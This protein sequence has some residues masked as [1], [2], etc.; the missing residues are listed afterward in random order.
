[1]L[2]TVLSAIAGHR[3]V[4]GHRHDIVG[5]HPVML[6]LAVLVA[7]LHHAAMKLHRI[8]HFRAREFPRI[9]VTQ[10]V[11]RVLHLPA[12]FDLLV[13]HAV[14]V[15]DA[16]AVAGQSDGCHGIEEAGSQSAKAA[17]AE[18]GIEFQFRNLVQVNARF[19]AGLAEFLC[20]AD[21]EHAVHQAAPDEEFHGEVIH[22]LCSHRCSNGAW[23]PSSVRPCVR[24]QRGRAK[25]TSRGQW[26]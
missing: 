21:V 17:V 4:I 7:V 23:F 16:H 8:K 24:E 19:D 13:E 12:V 6:H 3:R 22:S 11:V 25:R 9:A 2:L 10:P 20:K 5:I 14:L 26:Q 1:M 15:T 18:R